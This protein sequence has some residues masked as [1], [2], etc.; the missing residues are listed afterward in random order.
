MHKNRIIIV[1]G[2]LIFF[3]AEGLLGFEPTTKRYLIE[4]LS[5]I[6]VVLAFLIER[7]GVFFLHWYK[8]DPVTPVAST[9]IESSEV[10]K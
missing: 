4:A 10:V 6:I 2:L 7:K 5:L 3:L 1:L 9:Y 8:K